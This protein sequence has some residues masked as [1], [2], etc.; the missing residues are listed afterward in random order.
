MG[1]EDAKCF[2]VYLCWIPVF[3]TIR[4]MDVEKRIA[5]GWWT[6][7]LHVPQMKTLEKNLQH[8]WWPSSLTK[9]MQWKKTKKNNA[10][11]S[12]LDQTIQLIRT[13]INF[14][15]CTVKGFIDWWST[16]R[17]R[18]AAALTNTAYNCIIIKG[19]IPKKKMTHFHLQFSPHKKYALD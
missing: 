1:N 19:T 7:N 10:F 5:H 17:L 2:L 13:G 11:P 8:E 12:L 9:S 6:F 16:R 14:I 15:G 18:M 4:I 3:V